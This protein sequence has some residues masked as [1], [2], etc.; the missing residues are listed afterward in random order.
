MEISMTYRAASLYAALAICIPFQL[1]AQTP[2]ELQ[3]SAQ[4]TED[5]G[6]NDSW[7]YRNPEASFSKY[8][9]F[10]IEPA[11]VYTNPTAKWGS[12]TP[13][14]RQKLAADMTDELREEISKSYGIAEQPAPDVAK[15]RL[16]LLGIN[17]VDN[18]QGVAATVT[19]VTPYGLA[20]NGVK[21]LA[22]KKGSFAGS[23]QLAF[24]LIDSQT[25]SLQFAAVRRRSPNA[26]DIGAAMTTEN[27]V[28]AVAEDIAEAVRKGLDKA[29][30][31]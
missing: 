20:I 21:S 2:P 12:T 22:G 27:T 1:V 8:K 9:R 23:V 15:M 16:T 6:K 31:R 3:S 30:G 24:E 26:L 25:E 4:L 7:S 11:V 5:E 17:P 19:K 10:I 18:G 13:E 28:K 14:Q 29:N